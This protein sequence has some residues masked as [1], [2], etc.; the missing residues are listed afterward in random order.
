MYYLNFE[1]GKPVAQIKGGIQNKK[2]VY[3]QNTDEV[4][5][6]SNCKKDNCNN[7]GD[8][9]LCKHMDNK[10]NHIVIKDGE[11]LPVPD[12]KQRDCLYLAGPSG[13]GKSTYA[14]LYIEQLK[15]IYPNMKFYIFSIK[16]KDDVLDKLNP[17]RIPLTNKL[18]ENPIELEELKN[19]IVLFDDIDTLHDRDI[20]KELQKLRDNLLEVGRDQNIYVISTGH[21]VTDYKKTRILLN[22]AKCITIFPDSGVSYGINRLLKTYIGLSQEQ[23]TY[24]KKLK[25]RWVTI[26]TKCPNYVL[27]QHEMFLLNDKLKGGKV[28]I[29]KEA[30]NFVKE[31]E[32][33]PLS[34]EEVLKICDNKANLL[35][36][37]DLLKNNNIDDALGKYGALILLYESKPGFGHWVTVFRRD[38]NTLEFFDA[39]AKPGIP[40]SELKFISKDFKYKSGQT[41]PHLLKLMAD[42]GNKIIYNDTKLQRMHNDINTCGRWVGMRL[43]LRSWSI[44]KFAEFFK[45]FKYPPDFIITILT[46]I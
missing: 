42:T 37:R 24:I 18:I 36:N 8:E 2:I 3:I 45:S 31:Q 22:E 39:I 5:Q 38:K 1:N 40:D 7:C 25:S 33:K 30:D 29:C 6:C 9:K 20:S 34:G 16:P 21:Q 27:S 44:E 11:F 26:C 35:T 19:S 23:I 46:I 17:L 15:K 41:H 4:K 10:L 12:I 32:E 43:K 13:S 28:E 14:S